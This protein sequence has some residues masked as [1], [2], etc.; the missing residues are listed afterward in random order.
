METAGEN[1]HNNIDNEWNEIRYSLTT[2]A[3]D[4]LGQRVRD[5]HNNWIDEIE[6][7]KREK[8]SR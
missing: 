3:E 7:L 6:I 1:Q 4:I 2:T 5:K 8:G